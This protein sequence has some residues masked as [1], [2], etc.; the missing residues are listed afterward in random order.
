MKKVFLGLFVFCILFFHSLYSQDT[1]TRQA[2]NNLLFGLWKNSS[3]DIRSFE[4]FQGKIVTLN[5]ESK[6]YGYF[7]GEIM[8]KDFKYLGNNE[9][10]FDFLF[11]SKQN[12]NLRSEWIKT[13]MTVTNNSYNIEALERSTYWFKKFDPA[14]YYLVEKKT[15]PAHEMRIEPFE[16][17]DKGL[18]TQNLLNGLPQNE[19]ITYNPNYYQEMYLHYLLMVKIVMLTLEIN[20][21]LILHIIL[22]LNFG[23][24]FFKGEVIILE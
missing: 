18:I 16:E 11:K 4:N 21:Y 2:F 10:K 3:G 23:S 17:I 12:G 5:S 8:Y 7:V 20:L 22:R 15:P 19:R 9:F 13:K 6:G 1:D 14:T 24:V